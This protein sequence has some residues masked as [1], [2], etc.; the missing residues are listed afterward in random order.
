MKVHLRMLGCRLNQ[1]EIDQMARQL[2]AQ[3][4][5]IVHTPE[6]A[7]QFIVNTCAVTQDAT[8]SSRQLIRELSKTNPT[9]QTT[10][11]GCYAQISPD[12]I[13]VLP[14]VVRVVDN[15]GK[16][17]LV[18]QITGVKVE[19]FDHEPFARESMG[20][21]RTRAFI[22]VQD[23]CDNSC[24]FCVTTIARG[25]GRSRPL[26]DV[27]EEINYLHTV[28]GYQEAVL[29]GVHLGSYGHDFGDHYG[30]SSLVRAIL[31]DTD[32]PRLRLSSLEPW[33]L[34]PDFF[35]LWSNPR[36]CRHLHLP[37]QSGCDATLKRMRRNTNQEN[38]R[39]LMN[40]ARAIIPDVCITSDVIVG[41][42]YETD[43][44]FEISKAFIQEMDFAGMHIFRY[45]RRP[46]TPAS[47]MRNH[48]DEP[49][50]KARSAELHAIAEA[51]Q[52]RYAMRFIGGEQPVLWEHVMG[53]TPDGFINVGYTDTYLRVK[54]IH[55]RPL[56]N[57][58][59][60]AQLGHY[61]EATQIIEGAVSVA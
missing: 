2:T 44:E 27:V 57:H 1:A 28:M 25:A 18:E 35:D 8:R 26:A 46:G 24:T 13:L 14:S 34:S 60:P 37:L 5:E 20:G 61:D 52:K 6:D 30:L 50:K 3:G 31:A 15:M 47:R 38:F 9:A 48:V 23:G 32:I 19:S 21:G 55:P 17:T 45:S 49:T 11:T 54:A 41:F 36:V 22:K 7:D 16:D 59:I 39:L 29:T 43:E 51:G 10:V 58:L 4:H 33:D 53:A 40:H 56:T 42:P 12:E